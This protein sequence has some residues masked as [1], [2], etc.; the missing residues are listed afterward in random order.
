MPIFN[1]NLKIRNK[2]LTAF[3]RWGFLLFMVILAAGCSSS[4]RRE[5]CVDPGGLSYSANSDSLG[6]EAFESLSS[7]EQKIRRA[8]ARSWLDRFS[9]EKHPNS[10]IRALGNA[11]GLAPDD[12]SIWLHQA[13]IWRWMGDYLKTVEC[14]EMAA[15]AVR[16][17]KPGVHL[18]SKREMQRRTALARAWLHYDRGEWQQGL[19]WARAARKIAPTDVSVRQIY[20]LLAGHSGMRSES[21]GIAENLARIDPS[22][23]DINWIKASYRV[24]TGQHRQAFNLMM[25]LQPNHAHQAECWRE[26]GEIA[27]SLGEYSRAGRWYRE[28][29]STLPF[30]TSNCL[31]IWNHPRLKPGSKR[32]WQNVWLAF[33]RYYVTG[34]YSAYTSLAFNRFQEA[35]NQENKN[36]W[37]G[38]VVNAAGALL[39]KDIDKPWAYRA[40]GMVFAYVGN[41]DRGIRDLKMA[42]ELLGRE[43]KPDSEVESTLGHLYLEKENHI[44]AEKYL[45][46]ALDLDPLAASAWR[47]LGLV[48]IMSGQI[49][50]AEDALTR[51]LEL[52]PDSATSWYNRGLLYLHGQNYGQAVEDLEKAA[53]LAPDNPEVI[54]LLQKAKMHQRQ[55]RP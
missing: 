24:S 5:S 46:I 50:E 41:T 6:I 35:K 10:R 27:E 49:E 16:N 22:Y 42:S 36:F 19:D 7:D 54:N 26:M 32:T 25:D 43:R 30:K 51:A 37:A 3:G 38:Q 13:H 48:L 21:M 12:P 31:N 45:K 52:D 18:W 47:D 9:E 1:L 23:S 39:R 40:R 2:N 34:S 4:S 55:N 28:S 8:E 53:G 33:D 15:L 44:Q 29:F 20:G 11:A 14:L 17:F